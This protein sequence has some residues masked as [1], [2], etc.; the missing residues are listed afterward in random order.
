MKAQGF[1]RAL[2]ALRSTVALFHRRFDW[3][4]VNMRKHSVAAIVGALN[5]HGVRYLIAGGLAVVAHGYVRF[6]AGVDIILDLGPDN[7]PRAI[8]ALTSLGYQAVVKVDA[9]L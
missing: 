2:R 1:R 9:G 3:T 4:S 7:V 8:A 5:T 6:T